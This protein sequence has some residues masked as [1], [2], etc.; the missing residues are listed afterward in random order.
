[1]A[2]IFPMGD[3]GPCQVFWGG[4]DLGYN[5]DVNVKFTDEQAPIKTAQTGSA[6]VDDIITG[7]IVEIECTMTRSTLAQ[8]EDVM[9]A[10]TLTADELMIGNPVGV[11]K[12]S[13]SKKLI[14]KRIIEGQVSLDEK[15]WLTFFI[16][17]PHAQAEWKFDVNTQRVTKAMFRAYPVEAVASGETYA[18]GDIAAIGYGQD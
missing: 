11:S 12:R 13:L 3:M 1:M 15:E 18:V 14:L 9:P 16:A 7:R 8:L 2:D 4:T 10:T 17:A 6:S 5:M